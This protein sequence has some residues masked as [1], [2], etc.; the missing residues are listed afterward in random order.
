MSD[1]APNEASPPPVDSDP[2]RRNIKYSAFATNLAR[3][4]AVI[5]AFFHQCTSDAIEDTFSF[6]ESCSDPDKRLDA[7]VDAA[8]YIESFPDSFWLDFDWW[9]TCRTVGERLAEEM[10]DLQ[11]FAD[12]DLGAR[13]RFS[14]T[15]ND[16]DDC[17]VPCDHSTA[18]DPNIP[19]KG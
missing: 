1:Q 12:F 11:V 17:V 4:T 18:A 16:I 2:V 6:K 3:T 7:V 9:E 5:F 8:R 19:T 13:G 14:F 15:S 10:M